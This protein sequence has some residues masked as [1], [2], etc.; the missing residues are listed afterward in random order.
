MILKLKYVPNI[1]R[2]ISNLSSKLCGASDSYLTADLRLEI[3]SKVWGIKFESSIIMLISRDLR[4]NKNQNKSLVQS[5]AW[6]ESLGITLWY[7]EWFVYHLQDQSM[8][9]SFQSKMGVRSSHFL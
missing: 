7:S 5:F 2:P 3:S 9:S 4:E 1:S 8:K 6:I